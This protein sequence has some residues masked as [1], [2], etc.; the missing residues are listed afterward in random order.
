ML[1]A[2][3][4]TPPRYVWGVCG[5]VISAASLGLFVRSRFV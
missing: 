2:A 5:L 4:L 3:F 1:S